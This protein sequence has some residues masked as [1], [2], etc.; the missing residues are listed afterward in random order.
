[1]ASTGRPQPGQ[2]TVA[3]WRR[4]DHHSDGPRID[5]INGRFVVA[6]IASY[7]DRGLV[8]AVCLLLQAALRQH[9]RSDLR[10]R[11]GLGV[12]LASH[13]AVIPDVAVVRQ[14]PEDTTALAAT[15]LVLA[16]DVVSAAS[17]EQ[18]C[19]GKLAA[20]AAGGV[21]YVW[22]VEPST[23][24]PP[25]VRCLELAGDHYVERFAVRAGEPVLMTAAPV[26]V[27]LDVDQLYADAA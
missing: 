10:A 11:T 21:R 9:G 25:A 15:D 17:R 2:H 13:H 8:D 3:D 19:V 16:V 4:L 14:Q 18:D 23:S 24:R 1:M 12:T 5:L 26:P 20:Y 27:S 22:R 6:P 7:L